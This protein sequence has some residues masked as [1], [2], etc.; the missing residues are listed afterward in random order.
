VLPVAIHRC[1]WSLITIPLLKPQSPIFNLTIL[2]ALRHPRQA[3]THSQPSI[4]H[5]HDDE[6]V[7]LASAYHG[8]RSLSLDH[9]IAARQQ[10]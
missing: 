4:T 9:D 2:V 6:V 7:F 3:L 5:Q 1:R 8:S 10:K